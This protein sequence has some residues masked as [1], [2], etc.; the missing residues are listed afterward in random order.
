MSKG[1][2]QLLT[3]IGLLLLLAGMICAYI[4]VPKGDSSSEEEEGT[5]NV[6]DNT[7]ELVNIE[8]DKVSEIS[9]ISENKEKE[10]HLKKDGDS[11]KFAD[12]D[13]IPVDLDQVDSLIG[14][15]SP[16]NASQKVQ[17]QDT[18]LSDYGLEEPAQ[19]V[20]FSTTDGK[21]YTFQFGTSVPDN[22][23]KYG[24]YGED[25]QVY[26]FSETFCNKFDVTKNSLIKKDA[27]DSIDSEYLISMEV[28]NKGIS[29]FKAEVVPDDQKIDA[30]TNWI[31]SKPYKKALAGSSTNDW[32]TLQDSFTDVSFDELVEYDSNKLEKYG[33]TEKNPAG[34]IEVKYF[35]VPEGYTMP[36]ATEAPNNSSSRTTGQNN[37][38]NKASLVPEKDR[39]NK[40]YTLC[41]GNKSEDGSSFYV[42]LKDNHN[43]YKMAKDT[44][45]S[46]LTVDAYT[47]MDHS[48]YST[49][50]TDIN[51]YDVTIGDQTISV[52]RTATGKKNSAGKETNTWTVNG[53]EVPEDKEE[54]FLS[55]YSKAYLLEFSSFAKKDV[56]PASD[57]PVLKVVYHEANRDVTVTYRPY[58]G[59]NFYR[60]DKNGMDYFLVD[61]LSV[62][63][64]IEAFK[65]LPDVVK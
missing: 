33:L 34:E 2:K 7:V 54:D 64:V 60:V 3:V 6:A 16:V 13:K 29:T 30:Y 20:S 63:A 51:G 1:K 14:G 49:L 65:T 37:I 47:Y 61:K 12:N 58:D 5:Q 59:T 15:I 11:W 56:K 39:I 52:T 4:F 35:D 46:M 42:R 27:I 57:K 9:I 36:T 28:K 10:I 31:I 19:T 22:G 62:D 18:S 45:E 23:G 26:A 53:K 44:V 50:A 43:V 55:P 32:K 25:S 38:K 41:V 21:T 8:K 17:G 40:G 48:I 24:I